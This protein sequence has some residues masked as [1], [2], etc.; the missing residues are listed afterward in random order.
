MRE[1]RMEVV[2]CSF[3]NLHSIKINITCL[4]L[5]TNNIIYIYI[6]Q[7]WLFTKM[8]KIIQVWKSLIIFNHLPSDMKNT[9]G[10][11]KRFKTILKNFLIIHFF[12]TLD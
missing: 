6:R 3:H 11:L 12:C 7:T 9:S 8:E 2:G 1:K 10:N 5:Y 4:F